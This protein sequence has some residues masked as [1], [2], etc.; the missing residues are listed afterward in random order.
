MRHEPM[1]LAFI[2][3]I[4]KYTSGSFVKGSAT[5]RAFEAANIHS[6]YSDKRFEKTFP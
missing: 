6:I 4:E 3:F 1:L 5:T 2:S